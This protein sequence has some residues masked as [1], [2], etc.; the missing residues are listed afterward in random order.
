MRK[1]G[2]NPR[3]VLRIR[4]V[5]PGT[6]SKN[7]GILTQK[8]VS[9]L[10][11]IWSGLLIPDFLGTLPG[12]GIHRSKRHRIPDP[13]PQHCPRHNGGVVDHAFLGTLR[14]ES[15]FKLVF[16]K[17]KNF[18]N[19]TIKQYCGN[20]TI[21]TVPVSAPYSACLFLHRKKLFYKEKIDKFHQ[22][23]CKMWVK[24]TKYT[25]LCC[26]CENFCAS[27]LLRFR[28]SYG[29]NLQFLRFRFRNTAV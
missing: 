13:D 9:K 17:E 19:T 8:I 25:I 27:I 2:C 1:Q 26:V 4:D 10:S 15:C 18:N 23:Y 20:I 6:P 24:E 21:F 5:Y 22:I 16:T 12:S 11:E 29:K 7:L 14:S 28:F 3:P